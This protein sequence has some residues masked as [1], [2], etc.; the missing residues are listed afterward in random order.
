MHARHRLAAALVIAAASLLTAAC[1]RTRLS[2]DP[3]PEAIEIVVRDTAGRVFAAAQ[4]AISDEGIPV[5]Q[6]DERAGFVSSR[7]VDV[8]ALHVRSPTDAYSGPEREVQFRFHV[9]PSLE[10]DAGTTRLLG[11]AVYRPLG[12]ELSRVAM[13]ARDHPAREVLSRMLE[14]IRGAAGER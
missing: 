5:D 11:E 13:V 6:V 3:V 1:A 12:R 10:G 7:F 8:G 14:R 9:R 4:R 2:R